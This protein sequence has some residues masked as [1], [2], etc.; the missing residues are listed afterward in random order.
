MAEKKK[1]SIKLK[2]TAAG[3]QQMGSTKD[4]Q[5]L[6]KRFHRD[7]DKV[8]GGIMTRAEFKKK[9]GK[10]VRETQSMIYAAE[11][12]AQSRDS[13]K[14]SRYEGEKK[15]AD[16]WEKY[17]DKGAKEERRKKGYASGGMVKSRTGATDYRKGGLTLNTT[18]KR[19][20]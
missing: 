2:K 18:G 10:T 9:Y 14:N 13:E 12:A 8:H 17:W 15:D 16:T 20:K 4:I 3:A 19:K 7:M 11:S 6:L 1:K 5:A